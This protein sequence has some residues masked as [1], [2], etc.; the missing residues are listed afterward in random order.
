MK[1]LETEDQSLFYALFMWSAGSKGI[2]ASVQSRGPSNIRPA[3]HEASI[4]LAYIGYS[5]RRNIVQYISIQHAIHLISFI[6]TARTSLFCFCEKL[7]EIH[8]TI[9]YFSMNAFARLCTHFS[10]YYLWGGTFGTAA[11]TGL[12]YQ[13]HMIGDCGEIDGMNIGRGNRSTRRKRA[14]AP[15]CPP[16]IPHD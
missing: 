15:L 16:Q 1:G 4:V 7:N 5:Q 12:L 3:L 2:Q 9:T 14:P 6:F 10:Y 13:P 8:D 11:T